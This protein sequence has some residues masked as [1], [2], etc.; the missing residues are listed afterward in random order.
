VLQERLRSR[1]CDKF[2]M[3]DPNFTI[4]FSYYAIKT[5]LSSIICLIKNINHSIDWICW[6]KKF[7]KA[8]CKEKKNRRGGEAWL[9]FMLSLL[10]LKNNDIFFKCHCHCSLHIFT[11][12]NIYFALKGTYSMRMTLLLMRYENRY[13]SLS[14]NMMYQ[15]HLCFIN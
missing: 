13:A 12:I 9:N 6:G 8:Q 7:M 11:Q 14:V 15:E 2:L 10:S 5:L 3:M 4:I 1:G